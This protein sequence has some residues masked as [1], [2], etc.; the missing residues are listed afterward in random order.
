MAVRLLSSALAVVLLAGAATALAGSGHGR[1]GTSTFEGTCQFSGLLQQSPPMT[2][3]PQPGE[4]TARAV[5]ACSGTLTD[6]K[7]RERSL[8]S[9]RARYFAR[10]RGDVSCGGGSATGKGFIRV[11]R[12]K[13][14]FRFSEVRGPGVAAVRLEGVA[15][16]SAAGEARVSEEEDP[17]AIAQKCSGAGLAE[18]RIDIDLATTPEISG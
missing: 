7:G 9:S 12:E 16:G 10:A 4:A 8:S 2:N 13:L 11:G 5:G 6:E 3:L 15:G 14:R 1:G 18:V 17:V